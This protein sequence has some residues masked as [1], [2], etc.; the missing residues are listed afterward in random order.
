MIQVPNVITSQGA[1]S[2]SSKHQNTLQR[3]LREFPDKPWDWRNMW[4]NPS[5][6]ID[7]LVEYRNKPWDWETISSGSGAVCH[8]GYTTGARITLLD[9]LQH[10]ELPWNWRSISFHP[11]LTLCD[12]LNHPGKPWCWYGVSRSPNIT[13]QD[14]LQ[15]PELPWNWSD[16]SANPNLTVEFILEHPD[17]PWRWDILSANFYE[18]DPRLES[19][20]LAKTFVIF[21]RISLQE[22]PDDVLSFIANLIFSTW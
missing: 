21:G 10:S 1:K 5:I 2:D 15:H 14:V 16:L 12:V 13:M 3:L 7:D 9:M 11:D 18:L 19:R 17:K 8:S 6:T 4:Q 20:I 22:I